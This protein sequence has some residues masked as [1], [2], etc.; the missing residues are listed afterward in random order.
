MNH[1]NNKIVE[2]AMAIHKLEVKLLQKMKK[3]LHF[4]DQGLDMWT[5]SM[6]NNKFKQHVK[7]GQAI[8]EKKWEFVAKHK[9]VQAELEDLG[10]DLEHDVEQIV[11]RLEEYGE[12][13]S[14][15]EWKKDIQE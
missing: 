13:L 1:P 3:D 11:D 7:E 12:F 9:K 10:H 5:L 8:D 14:N 4:N 15:P 6:D 2:E